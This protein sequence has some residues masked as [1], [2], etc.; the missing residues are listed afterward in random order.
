MA[1]VLLENGVQQGDTVIIFMPM[2]PEAVIAMLSCARIGAVHSV[3][4]GGFASEELSIRLNNIKPKVI[5]AASCGVEKS[6][7]IPYMP[8]VNKA[9]DLSKDVHKIE[10]CIVFQRPEYIEHGLHRERDVEWHHAIQNLSELTTDCTVVES[11]HPLYV[12]YTSGTTGDPKGIQRDH[13]G[14][15]VALLYT[16]A[17]IYGVQPGDVFWAASDVG[18]VVGH[19]YS[20]YGPL[21]SGCTT[22]IYEGKPV[23]TPDEKA[24]WRVIEKYRVNILSTA[25]TALRAIKRED[26]EGTSARGYDM[27]SLRGVYLAGERAD[28]DSLEWAE[29]AIGVP[30]RDHWWQTETG[31][32][33]CSNLVALEGLLPKKHGSTYRPCPGYDVQVLQSTEERREKTE[34]TR[35]QPNQLGALVIRLPLPPGSMTTLFRDDER[36]VKSYLTEY[37]GYYSTGDE[38][39][40]DEDGY[41]FV[42]SRTDDVINVAGHRIS[43]SRI[44]EVVASHPDVAEVAVVGLPDE[45]RG[46][47]PFGLIVLNQNCTKAQDI[48]IDD[49]VEQV[50]EQIGAFAVFKKAI[51]VPC[52][53]KTRSGKILRGTLRKIVNKQNYKMPA[54]IE[55]P[56]VLYDIEKQI[57]EI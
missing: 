2:I 22:V 57:N 23:G 13:G 39:M 56:L 10:R 6:K 30:V 33:I 1:S 45:F 47:V 52:L 7:I 42:M 18:W 28:H 54:T 35:A 15:A 55:D 48:I 11:T 5:L 16:M 8:L 41:V 32:P 27:T 34:Y 37:P 40:I 21:L 24:F 49:V 20:V 51:C 14:Y 26:S 4:F 36:Y 46:E 19:S 29:R 25:P 9:I 53:P 44:E 43:S 50:R 38:G 3:V 31:W 12:L 17:N